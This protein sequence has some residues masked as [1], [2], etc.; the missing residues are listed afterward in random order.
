MVF[1]QAAAKPLGPAG[2]CIDRAEKGHVELLVSTEIV[3]EVRDVLNRPAIQRKFR[4]LTPERAA[5][6]IARVERVAVIFDPVPNAFSFCRDPKDSMYLN[7]AIAG[8]AELVVSRDKDLLD[9]MT[10]TDSESTA[11]RTAYPN[12]RIVNPVAFLQTFRPATPA[13]PDLPPPANP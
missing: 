1:L 9:L 13:A 2:A 12:I 10:S 7:L 3:E 11:F 6:I 5:D 4:T 8:S